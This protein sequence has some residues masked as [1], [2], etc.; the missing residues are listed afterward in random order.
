LSCDVMRRLAYCSATVATLRGALSA[1]Y[2]QAAAH[3]TRREVQYAYARLA[4]LQVGRCAAIRPAIA[5][6]RR[7]RPARWG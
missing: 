6:V 4:Q 1:G 7:S 2:L 5:R 3:E